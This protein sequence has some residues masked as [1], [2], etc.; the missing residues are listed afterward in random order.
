MITVCI[1]VVI[2]DLIKDAIGTIN[3]GDKGYMTDKAIYFVYH[4]YNKS[5]NVSGLLGEPISIKHDEIKKILGRNTTA[6]IKALE[7]KGVITVDHYYS[8]KRRKCKRYYLDPKMCQGTYITI[9]INHTPRDYIQH[10]TD[11]VLNQYRLD[12]HHATEIILGYAGD[13]TKILSKAIIGEDIGEERLFKVRVY[14][15][16]NTGL[17][18]WKSVINVRKDFFLKK[19]YDPQCILIKWNKRYYYMPR[20]DFINERRRCVKFSYTNILNRFNEDQ[21]SCTVDSNGRLYSKITNLPKLIMPVLYHLKYGYELEE[22]DLKCAQ[23]VFLVYAVDNPD[24]DNIISKYVLDIGFT[25]AADDWTKFKSLVKRGELYEY[26]QEQLGL[27]DRGRAKALC[28]EILFGKVFNKDSH[29]TSCLRKLFPS[30]LQLV[31]GIK[32]SMVTSH[33]QMSCNRSRQRL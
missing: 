33:Y 5:L 1:P 14:S 16:R 21:P 28:F 24:L 9:S 20:R 25:H 7:S 23:W 13:K 18:K 22:W 8:K 32:K 6:I 12:I 26:I 19:F 30:L 31:E 11:E 29:Y 2:H 4:L 3:K 27:A 15:T 17:Y 10:K